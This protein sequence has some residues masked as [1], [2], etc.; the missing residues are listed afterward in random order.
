MLLRNDQGKLI[1]CCAKALQGPNNSKEEEVKAI[2]EALSWLLQQRLSHVMIETYA[3]IACKAIL[4][5]TE[6]R[7]EFGALITDCR[8]WLQE[9]NFTIFH[10]KRKANKVADVLTKRA[11]RHKIS[12]LWQTVPSFF[13][14]ALATDGQ[15]F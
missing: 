8:H 13:V 2:R 4:T 15:I 5:S 6:D 3:K 10:V 1:S 14:D 9:G 12:G 11:F 7:S